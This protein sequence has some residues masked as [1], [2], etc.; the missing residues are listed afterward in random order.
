[1]QMFLGPCAAGHVW[2]PDDRQS[3]SSYHPVSFR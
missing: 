3:T 2:A 1:M